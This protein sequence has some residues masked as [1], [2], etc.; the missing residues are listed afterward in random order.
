MHFHSHSVISYHLQT[1]YSI[2]YKKLPEMSFREEIRGVTELDPVTII[3]FVAEEQLNS[4][5][6]MTVIATVIVAVLNQEL[7]MNHCL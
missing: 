7:P 2:A 5:S 6:F 3:F 4:R 1:V